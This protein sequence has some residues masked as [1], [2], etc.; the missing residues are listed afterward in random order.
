MAGSYQIANGPEPKPAGSPGFFPMRDDGPD[1]SR[2][3]G[4]SPRALWTP[5]IGLVC[6]GDIEGTMTLGPRW[7][8]VKHLDDDAVRSLDRISDV[9]PHR[10]T[11]TPFLSHLLQTGVRGGELVLI[12]EATGR[13]IARL[14]VRS[15][16]RRG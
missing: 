16:V 10:S 1:R 4:G 14:A 3:K 2:D 5:A 11:L 12:E 6:L 15:P 9:S 13:T 8:R 7:Y